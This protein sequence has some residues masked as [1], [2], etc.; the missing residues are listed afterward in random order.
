MSSTYY[1]MNYTYLL[2][3]AGLGGLTYYGYKN[4]DFFIPY[5]VN[6][7]RYYHIVTDFL[8]GTPIGSYLLLFS[9]MRFITLKVKE[10]FQRNM[11]G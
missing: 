8:M 5:V 9:I 11:T 4:P 3:G 2:V 1:S 7:I 10:R 6:T